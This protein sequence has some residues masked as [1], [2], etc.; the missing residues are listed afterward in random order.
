MSAK[1]IVKDVPSKDKVVVYTTMP[2]GIVAPKLYTEV[3]ASALLPL[4]TGQYAY[5]GEQ[6][7][8]KGV[9]YLGRKNGLKDA[10]RKVVKAGSEVNKVQNSGN[11][12]QNQG[13]TSSDAMQ[14]KLDALARGRETAR[15]NREARKN[16]SQPQQDEN[17]MLVL[18]TPDSSGLTAAQ[19]RIVENLVRMGEFDEANTLV[20][21]WS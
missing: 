19:Q 11:S 14:R 16:A 18:D 1:L 8:S 17:T 4:F 13:G 15:K 2:K 6:L 5:I 20:S 21:K 7:A 3:D 12:S 9:S 10:I